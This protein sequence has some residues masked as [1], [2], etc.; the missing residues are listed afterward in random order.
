MLYIPSFHI[1]KL[2]SYITCQNIFHFH[3]FF[4]TFY[5]NRNNRFLTTFNNF[6]SICFVDSENSNRFLSD[7]TKIDRGSPFFDQRIDPSNVYFSPQKWTNS[8]LKK[9]FG[10]NTFSIVLQREFQSRHFCDKV[11]SIFSK[12]CDKCYI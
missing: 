11:E 9:I 7:F 6:I 2:M 5:A 3:V 8:A 4:P 1:N 10:N 12:N